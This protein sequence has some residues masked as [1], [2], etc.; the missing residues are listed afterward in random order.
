MKPI[1]RIIEDIKY[2][3]KLYKVKA[4]DFYTTDKELNQELYIEQDKTVMD[5]Y[6]GEINRRKVV[7]HQIIFEN[8]QKIPYVMLKYLGN[9][10][11]EDIITHKK[12]SHLTIEKINDRDYTLVPREQTTCLIGAKVNLANFLN[13]NK[14]ANALP[15]TGENKKHIRK[16]FDEAEKLIQSGNLLSTIKQRNEEK[17]RR[18]KEK[19]DIEEKRKKIIEYQTKRII[20][21]VIYKFL[22]NKNN[23]RVDY[24]RPL[25]DANRLFYGSYSDIKYVTEKSEPTT[26][27]DYLDD[28]MPVD[29][30]SYS[31]ISYN[32][33]LGGSGIFYKEG[34]N[35]YTDFVRDDKKSIKEQ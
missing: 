34:E 7:K 31:T 14:G 1:K 9:G 6:D 18:E 25:Y 10:I 30:T 13:T 29:Y 12:I 15:Y 20:H 11:F 35:Q 4:E 2:R 17:K 16:E 24:D 8:P 26:G 32:K 5:E 3:G 19:A 27:I 33:E 21:E 28:G 23:N 22:E